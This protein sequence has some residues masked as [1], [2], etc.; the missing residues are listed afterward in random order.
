MSFAIKACEFEKAE[1]SFAH[2]F[3]FGDRSRCLRFDDG[4][5]G[6]RCSLLASFAAS[7]VGM[8]SKMSSELVGSTEPLGA[9]FKGAGM[10][11]LARVSSQMPRLM[12]QSIKSAIAHRAFVRPERFVKTASAW[13]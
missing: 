11:F 13:F 4:W 5:L 1:F 6:G 8:N 7:R 2:K 3:N 10:R 12:L 9:A